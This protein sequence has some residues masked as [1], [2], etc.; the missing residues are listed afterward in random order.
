MN[1]GLF[2]SNTDN[3]ATPQ[4]L[5]DDL[6]KEFHFTLDVCAD[7]QN[8]K[9]EK[10]YTKADDGL[11][12][13]W[14]GSVFMN[15]PYGREIA[16][17]I[18][19]AYS[20]RANC[21]TIVMLVPARTDTSWFHD[22]IY[23]EAEIRFLRGRV[24]FEGAKWNAPFP[25]MVAIYRKIDEELPLLKWF[26]EEQKKCPYFGAEIEICDDLSDFRPAREDVEKAFEMYKKHRFPK[27]CDNC[28]HAWVD[29]APRDDRSC[30]S[31]EEK[32]VEQCQPK[33]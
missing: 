23:H 3:W 29:C 15:P 20:E 27:N 14:E 8:H 9:C 13:S 18:W 6:D 21:K 30:F 1:K 17:W 12:N 26:E 28:K 33:E 2:T 7:D 5:F 10:Y 22:Y 31:W 11:K 4:W 24:R 16:K 25:S 19:K 32:E